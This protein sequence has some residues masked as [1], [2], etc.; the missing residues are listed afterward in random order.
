MGT[1]RQLVAL[2]Q[3]KEFYLRAGATFVAIISVASALI[4]IADIHLNF[5]GAVALTLL[6][7]LLS[8]AV[9]FRHLIVPQVV[10]DDVLAADID[11]NAQTY[12]HCPCDLKLASAAKKL[13][14]SCYAMSVTIE[15]DTFEQFRVKNP[16]ILAC[17]TDSQS[18]FV[19]YFDAIPL[20]E[21][22][23]KPFLQGLVT[24]AQ[25]THEDVL[26]PEQMPS[27][28]YLFISG[29][30]VKGPLAYSGRRNASILAWALLKY[31][32]YFYSSARPLTFALGAT[33]AGNELLLRFRAKRQAQAG[34]RLDGYKLYSIV[35]SHNEIDRRLAC[36]PSWEHL[37]SLD[38]T[39]IVE[40]PKGEPRRRRRPQP[41]RARAWDLASSDTLS[42]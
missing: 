30:A 11:A 26:A 8:C 16:Y 7:L 25:I 28:R 17:L 34:T 14:E 32:D 21:S 42:A 41:P 1:P 20:R 38:W 37:C 5:G 24:E 9:N 40:R 2:A 22:F 33:A 39:P 29:F 31:L 12:L 36:L 4:T 27:C 18:Q 23:A 6:A 13:A 10:V 19:G 15:P 35:L 3:R